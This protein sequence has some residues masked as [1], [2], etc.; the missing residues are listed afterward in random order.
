MKK[1]A[2]LE[3]VRVFTNKLHIEHFFISVDAVYRFLINGEPQK[4]DADVG[5]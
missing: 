4:E 5:S 3:N 2:L 1:K